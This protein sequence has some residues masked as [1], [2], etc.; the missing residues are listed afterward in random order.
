VL[1]DSGSKSKL[2]LLGNLLLAITPA[3]QDWS[4]RLNLPAVARFELSGLVLKTDPV[5]K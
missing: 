5:R 3:A 2:A 4:S 1:V